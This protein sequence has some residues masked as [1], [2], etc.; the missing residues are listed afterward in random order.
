MLS[1]SKKPNI[2]SNSWAAGPRALNDTSH[3]VKTVSSRYCQTAVGGFLA[4]T[5]VKAPSNR[6]R[7]VERNL[8]RA[9]IRAGLVEGK[10]KRTKFPDNSYGITLLY[11]GK[12]HIRIC[13]DIITFTIFSAASGY[14]SGKSPDPYLHSSGVFQ[15]YY[16]LDFKCFPDP[17]RI[18]GPICNE[19]AT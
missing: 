3:V 10:W 9:D 12:I 2:R 6:S 19:N 18:P 8:H 5:L 7:L 17:A 4:V 11:I 15:A 16:H 13:N 14:L 1:L